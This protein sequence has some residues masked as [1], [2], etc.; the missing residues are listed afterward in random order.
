MTSP[1]FPSAE[2]TLSWTKYRYMSVSSSA[3]HFSAHPSLLGTELHILPFLHSSLL[4]YLSSL[5]SHFHSLLFLFSSSSLF[6]SSLLPS[7]LPLSSL[8]SAPSSAL[9]PP[10]FFPPP[11]SFFPPPPFFFPL[12]PSPAFFL[13]MLSLPS[14]SSHN[15]DIFMG[16]HGSGLTHLLFLPDWAGA[17]EM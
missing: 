17:F 8:I 12:P 1:S 5:I 11:P 2:S 15:S 9:L 7:L 4:P 10:F 13:I 3:L 14:Q 16:I 6:A